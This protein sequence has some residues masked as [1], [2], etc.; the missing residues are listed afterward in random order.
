MKKV[1]FS[2]C[3]LFALLAFTSNPRGINDNNTTVVQNGS[4]LS[5]DLLGINEV[6]VTGDPD[7][8]GHVELVLNQGQGTISYMITVEGIQTPTAAHIHLGSPGPVVVGLSAPVNGMSSGVV[9]V[10]K[11]LVKAIRK[12]PEM[13]YVNVHNPTYPGG[14]LRGQLAK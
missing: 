13:Y 2:G 5:A 6:P 7:G 11:E 9:E 8:M 12:N 1:L 4:T 3:V 10:D 14:A